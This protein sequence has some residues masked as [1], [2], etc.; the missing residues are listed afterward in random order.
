MANNMIGLNLAT[1]AGEGGADV[2]TWNNLDNAAKLLYAEQKQKEAQAVRDFSVADEILKRDIGGIRSA[3]TDE[4]FNKYNKVKELRKAL[5]FDE[6]AKKDPKKFAELQRLA[7]LEE[8]DLRQSILESKEVKELDKGVTQR[9]GSHRDDFDDEKIPTFYQALQLPTSERRKL[10]LI[11][12][13][14]FRSQLPD[15]AKL[16]QLSKTAMGTPKEVPFGDAVEADGGYRLEQKILMRGNNP[17]QYADLLYKGLQSNK[18]GQGARSLYNQMPEERKQQIRKQFLDIPDADFQ[19]KWGVKKENLLSMFNNDDKAGQYVMLEAMKYAVDNM[20]QF[21]QSDFRTNNKFVDETKKEEYNRRFKLQEGG[22]N[23]RAAMI[24]KGG[25]QLDPQVAIDEIYDL[26]QETNLGYRVKAGG[27]LIY[28]K[29]V[30]LT[31]ELESDFFDKSDGKVQRPAHTV[32]SHDKTKLYFIYKDAE[33]KVNEKKSR[34]VNVPTD[35]KSSIAK[36][37]GGTVFTRK[38]LFSGSKAQPENKN[39]KPTAA[40]RVR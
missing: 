32:M 27:D 34:V 20:P 23:F 38:N 26:G 13:T 17:L 19:S 39:Q 33:G 3:D 14:P 28:G 37:Y 25:G 21:G 12:D 15:M 11:G 35:L 24:A 22:K 36:N 9:I 29:E 10:G 8:N 31:P 5:Y 40:G 2:M 6:K 4:I 7:Q 16:Q 1:R 30:T 18:Y